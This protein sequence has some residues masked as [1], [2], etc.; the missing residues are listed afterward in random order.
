MGI[1][2]I[3]LQDTM[4]NMTDLK[5]E[6]KSCLAKYVPLTILILYSVSVGLVFVKVNRFHGFLCF[7]ALGYRHSAGYQLR[8]RLQISHLALSALKGIN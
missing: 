5:N 6:I 1:V 8:G 7:A 2:D 3:S 4:L